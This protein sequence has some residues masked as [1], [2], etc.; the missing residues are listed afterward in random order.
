VWAE[1]RDF[2]S[3]ETPYVSTTKYNRFKLFGEIFAVYIENHTEHTDTLC[4]KN[5]QFNFTGNTLR[6]HYKA[7]HVNAL[8]E[9]VVVYCVYTLCKHNIE[10]ASHRKHINSPL[11]SPS[12][13]II[14]AY[15]ENH[16]EYLDTLC[17]QNV[18]F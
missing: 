4:G 17:G 9:K 6:L 10:F 7:Q 1:C 12:G 13:E 16:M 8:R 14:A 3:K 18:E 11:Q 2:T 5:V 15:C